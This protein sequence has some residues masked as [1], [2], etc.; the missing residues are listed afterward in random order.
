[1]SDTPPNFDYERYAAAPGVV[2]LPSFDVGAV[3]RAS[4]KLIE[5][6]WLLVVVMTA[7]IMI[8]PKLALVATHL[9]LHNT[10]P[11]GHP[12]YDFLFSAND[13]WDVV[14]YTIWLIVLGWALVR[15]Q[16]GHI[17]SW[18][19]FFG[20]MVAL[21]V[22][23][24]LSGLGVLIGFVFLIVPGLM[25]LVAWSVAP[26]VLIM[27]KCTPTQ[28]LGRSRDL[29]RGYSWP[30]F[31]LLVLTTVVIFLWEGGVEIVGQ[32]LE[33]AFPHQHVDWMFEAIVVPWGSLPSLA[34]SVALY[35]YLVSLR[36]G[37]A[38]AKIAEVFD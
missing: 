31:G 22:L 33:D 6:N 28:A 25:L 5:G 32:V 14:G 38:D 8:L 27:E 18:G 10:H 30:I 26:A 15:R 16:S 13:I 23:S 36:E 12:L 19:A 34:I 7:A 11:D 9:L 3:V 17:V 1:M 24:F 37:G 21:V 20:V 4:A 35:F 29:C 2:S